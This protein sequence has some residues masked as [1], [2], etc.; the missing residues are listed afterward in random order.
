MNQY[1]LDNLNNPVLEPD[2]TKYGQWMQARENRRL[3]IHRMPDGTKVSTV[4]LGLDHGWNGG[5]PVLWETMVFGG[6][7]DQEQDRYISYDE[8]VQGHRQWVKRVEEAFETENSC[9]LTVHES[10][11]V[12]N[13]VVET[14]DLEA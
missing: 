8:A 4:F 6:K 1:I 12:I 10:T 11:K 13:Q 3:G 5:P 9:T 7:Y 2:Y 14:K